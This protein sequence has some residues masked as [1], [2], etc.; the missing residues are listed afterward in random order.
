MDVKS[1]RTLWAEDEINQ[2]RQYVVDFEQM[3][4][5]YVFPAGRRIGLVV[6]GKDNRIFAPDG[7]APATIDLKLELS[8]IRLPIVGG[9]P[10]LGF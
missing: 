1:V 2:R 5:D 4:K 10:A 9:R 3:P 7:A 6:T 8:R